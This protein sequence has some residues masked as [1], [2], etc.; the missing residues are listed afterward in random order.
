MTNAADFRRIALA[1]PGAAEYPHFDRRAFKA[2]VTFATLA[3]DGLTANIKFAPDEQALKCAVA[4]DALRRSRT[5]GGGRAG[6]ARRLR[7]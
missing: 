2:R 6:L 5:P 1:L 7:P 4:P 3:P